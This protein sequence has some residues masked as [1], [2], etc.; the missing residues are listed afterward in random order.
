MLCAKM[1]WALMIPC[2]NFKTVN[3]KTWNSNLKRRNLAPDETAKIIIII[4]IVIIITR[5]CS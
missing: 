1:A 4:I 2:F 5:I 3:G